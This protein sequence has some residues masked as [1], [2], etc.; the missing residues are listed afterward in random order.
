MSSPLYDMKLSD[1]D[2]NHLLSFALTAAERAGSYIQSRVGQHLETGTKEAGNT[3]A[4]QI[5]TEVDL[6][7]QRLI[8]ATLQDSIDEYRLGL[9]T[10]EGVDDSSRLETDHFWC[11]DPLDGTLPFVNRT[12]GY[13]VSI[14][15][16]SRT[17]ESQIG[18]IHDPDRGD[19]FHAVKGRG[20]FLNG[21]SIPSRFESKGKPLTW[22]MD[23]S[24]KRSEDYPR[25]TDLMEDLAEK[26]ECSGLSIIDHAGAALNGAWVTQHAPAIYFKFP[27]KAKGGGSLW[28]FAASACLLNEWGQPATDVCG[29]PLDLNRA[30]TTY[31]NERGIIY[32]SDTGLRETVQL[33]N[34]QWN[35]RVS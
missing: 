12:P 32:A 20:A 34:R 27:K 18:V 28:D 23:R 11:I 13:S 31:M 8:L 19:T 30:D 29:C 4:S 3:L 7:S 16:V 14:A 35:E 24:M 33:I 9:L 5:V 25:L 15:L 2:F 6:E 21:E 1:S 10:E 26:S 22:M 17:G